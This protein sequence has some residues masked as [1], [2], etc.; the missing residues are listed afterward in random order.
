MNGDELGLKYSVSR[1]KEAQTVRPICS[2]AEASRHGNVML[3]SPSMGSPRCFAYQ[4]F[5]AS[6]SRDLKKMPPSPVTRFIGRD[7]GPC[8]N[9]SIR[10]DGQGPTYKRI[11]FPFQT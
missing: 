7:L 5:T 3:P 10:N 6:G 1:G 8:G 9:P 4:F 11:Y 2:G